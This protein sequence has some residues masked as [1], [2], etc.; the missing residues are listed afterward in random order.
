MWFIECQLLS[1][2]C[3]V[4][5]CAQL[6][7]LV[8][9]YYTIMYSNLYNNY[10]VNVG[11]KCVY[12]YMHTLKS[13]KKLF[14]HKSTRE[15]PPI[16]YISAKTPLPVNIRT[17]SSTG[18][19]VDCSA[20]LVGWPEQ[21]PPTL[22]WVWSPHLLSACHRQFRERCLPTNAKPRHLKLDYMSITCT[23]TCT[24]MY[25]YYI[26]MVSMGISVCQSGGR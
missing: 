7:T 10:A 12:M 17:I 5:S 26:I 11:S 1:H 4:T 18:W 9:I 22:C 2:T 8:N 24:C 13:S 3:I 14:F 16:P 23:Y 25:M 21:P 15:A 6:Y 19:H 20:W